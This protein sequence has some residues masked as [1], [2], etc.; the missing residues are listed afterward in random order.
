MGLIV[1][2]V[3]IVLFVILKKRRESKQEIDS[4]EYAPKST[5]KHLM[6]VP[7]SS[8]MFDFDNGTIEMNGKSKKNKMGKHMMAVPSSSALSME[9]NINETMR[10]SIRTNHLS[11]PSSFNVMDNLTQNDAK[12]CAQC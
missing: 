2:C 11:L 3:V 4:S 5:P 6:A 8:A 1:F 12:K 7:S 9:S 10:S